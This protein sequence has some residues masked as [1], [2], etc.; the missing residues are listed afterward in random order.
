MR[1]SARNGQYTKWPYNYGVH[2]VYLLD[3]SYDRY[4]ARFSRLFV[5][6][7]VLRIQSTTT[8]TSAFASSPLVQKPMKV[9]QL[10]EIS[11]GSSVSVGC[12]QVS[13]SYLT[14]PSAR[15]S[16]T[17]HFSIRFQ[18][19]STFRESAAKQVVFHHDIPLQFDW[20]SALSHFPR[21]SCNPL[22]LTSAQLHL[23]RV[24]SS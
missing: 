13:R 7:S 6:F 24:F 9:A 14:H 23:A 19:S 3:T 2:L 8:K 16:M 4:S 11:F 1:L 21:K 20:S 22:D 12:L 5:F 15:S 17:F 10:L 18:L